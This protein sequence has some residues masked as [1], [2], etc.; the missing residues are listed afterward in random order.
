MTDL[1]NGIEKRNQAIKRGIDKR[2]LAEMICI[3][4]SFSAIA[5][6]AVFYI[7][8]RIQ[9]VNLGY[10]TQKLRMAEELQL[11]AARNLTLEVET[12]KDPGRID[13]IARQ[14]LGMMPL[15]PSQIIPVGF[16]AEQPGGPVAL[17]MA[18]NTRGNG[19]GKTSANN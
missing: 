12:L 7:W 17:A 4:L 15:R 8:V 18:G 2:H 19:P 6:V 16:R 13:L 10:E 3:V 1:A 11:R 14:Q 9:T 5:I